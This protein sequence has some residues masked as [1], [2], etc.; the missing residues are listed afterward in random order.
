MAEIVNL[1]RARKARLRREKESEAAANRQRFGE[2]V[3]LAELRRR[4]QEQTD[5]RHAAHRREVDGES[6]GD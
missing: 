4:R 1:R 2:P 6:P 5:S 3:R